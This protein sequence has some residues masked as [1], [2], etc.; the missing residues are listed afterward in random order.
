[1]VGGSS[2]GR[3]WEFFFSPPCPERLW[4]TGSLFLGVKW[5][6]SEADHSTPYSAEV[7]ECVDPYFHSP[8]TP[9]WRSVQLK[10]ST[11]TTL[12]YL[13]PVIEVMFQ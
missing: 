8:S 7:K 4:V 5:L 1:M 3:D 13:L 2:P 6:G 10:K 9:S 11:V 12:P